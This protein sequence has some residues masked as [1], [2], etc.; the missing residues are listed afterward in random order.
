MR[1]DDQQQNH[2]FSYSAPGMPGVFSARGRASAGKRVQP[3]FRWRKSG[4]TCVSSR[5]ELE[6]E[7]TKTLEIKPFDII[8][9]FTTLRKTRCESIFQQ[10][11]SETKFCCLSIVKI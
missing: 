8:N 9:D 11:A 6:A 4:P 2:V 3:Q 1:G 5:I 7:A 10:P